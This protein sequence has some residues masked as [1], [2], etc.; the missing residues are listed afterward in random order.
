MYGVQGLTGT[1]TSASGPGTIAFVKAVASRGVNPL[2][3]QS[4]S[5]APGW[6]QASC[7]RAGH[8]VCFF[9]GCDLRRDLCHQHRLQLSGP[10]GDLPTPAA[11]P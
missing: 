1:L 9:L 4:V 6:G 2:Q 11:C 7:A 3:G 8:C 10:R 5:V